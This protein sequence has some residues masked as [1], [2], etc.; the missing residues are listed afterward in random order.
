VKKKPTGETTEEK[1]MIS[2]IRH[3]LVLLG[4]LAGLLL[5]PQG[6][7]GDYIDSNGLRVTDAGVIVVMLSTDPTYDPAQT[8]RNSRG[9]LTTFD[10]KLVIDGTSLPWF[11]SSPAALI[12]TKAAGD[13]PTT[14][15]CVKWVAGGGIGDGGAACGAISGSGT[16][17]YLPKFTGATTLGDSLVSDDGTTLTYAGTGGINVASLTATSEKPSN[18]TPAAVPGSPVAGD[19]GILAGSPDLFWFF[20]DTA[21]QYALTKPVDLYGSS[22]AALLVTK[23]AG[24]DPTTN[25]CVKWVAGGKLDDAGAACGGGGTTPDPTKFVPASTDFLWNGATSTALIAPWFAA[26]TVSGTST[27]V[28]GTANH[29]GI[30]TLT[31]S[32]SGN[33]G[34]AYALGTSSFLLAGTE[35]TEFIF[36]V[37]TTAN[38]TAR[39]GFQ[40]SNSSTAPTDGAWV[41]IAATTLDGRTA[42]NT[43]GSTTGT[44]YTITASVWYRAK[45]VVNSDATQVDFYLYTCADGVQ[46]WTNNLTTNIPTAAG[47]ET[48]QSAMA[49]NS[50]TTALELVDL[51][52]MDV[53]MTRTLTR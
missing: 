22:P 7:R 40:D 49:T 34:Y 2:R 37:V 41:N 46:V 6:L 50:G 19:W 43:T 21:V 20:N 14:N 8:I 44:N 33:S 23:A 1:P 31:S 38:T 11:G 5:R 39:L 25:N 42:S 3:L 15:N 27:A 28:T 32:T 51:D 4:L 13:D 30:V 17:N 52:F 45:V 16:T 53:Y 47:R 48:G 24:A 35:V 9:F 26:A 29:P 12:V 36:Q 10:G 18:I